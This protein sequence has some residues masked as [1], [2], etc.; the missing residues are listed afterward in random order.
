MGYTGRALRHRPG[1][2]DGGRR[3]RRTAIEILPA[4]GES[5]PI[6]RIGDNERVTY[7]DWSA[8][9]ETLVYLVEPSDT[10]ANPVR[11][12]STSSRPAPSRSASPASPP[13]TAEPCSHPY[14]DLLAFTRYQFDPDYSADALVTRFP[15]RQR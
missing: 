5:K 11:A 7:M 3:E 2:E 10:T 13:A 12:T 1:P 6:A 4:D 8:S 9:G 14:G 15:V